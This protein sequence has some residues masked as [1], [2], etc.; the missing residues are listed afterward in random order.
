MIVMAYVKQIRTKAITIKKNRAELGADPPYEAK[1]HD[2]ERIW[3][4]FR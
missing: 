1:F 3:Y 2:R 4:G